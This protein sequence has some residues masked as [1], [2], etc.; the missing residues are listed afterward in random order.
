MPHDSLYIGLMS[1][2]S[3]DGIDAA[4]VDFADGCRVLSTL[5]VTYPPNIRTALRDLVQHNGLCVLDELGSL[6]QWLGHLFGQSVIELLEQSHYSPEQITAIGS[7]GQTIHHRPPNSSSGHVPYTLQIGD[8]NVIVETTGIT[9]V[10]DFRRRDMA[11]GGQGAPLV[12]AFHAAVFGKAGQDRA[13]VNIGGIANISFINAN[14]SIYGFDIGPG[15]CLMDQWTQYAFKLPYDASGDL[16]A[17]GNLISGLL[18]RL[19]EEPYF[20]QPY[21]KSTGPEYFNLDWLREHLS[22]SDINQHNILKTLNQLTAVTIAEV[23]KHHAPT[24]EAA[25]FCGGGT[26]NSTLMA[27]LKIELPD[28]YIDTTAALGVDPDFVE[29]AAFAWLAKQTL[30]KNPGNVPLVTGANKSVILGGIYY[31]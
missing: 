31:C 1:G 14:A 12:P 10:A 18:T 2:T 17:H 19:L 28:T 4:L 7:H 8:P 13:I 29:A 21:P 6:D 20:R 22:S 9:T 16:A 26:H 25:F 27:S 15:N 30:G 5:Y 3:M 24:L 23:I 11:A